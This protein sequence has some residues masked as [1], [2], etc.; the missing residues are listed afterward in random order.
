MLILYAMLEKSHLFIYKPRERDVLMREFLCACDNCLKL[1]LEQ[2]LTFE[3]DS[4]ISSVS[5]EA[6]EDEC[7]LDAE[8][9][10][11]VDADEALY[12]FDFVEVPSH[13]A[14]VSGKMAEPLYFIKV[15]EKGKAS[16][17]MYDQWN[18]VNLPGELYLKGNYL[19]K[20]RSKSPKKKNSRFLISRYY[21]NQ[22]KCLNYF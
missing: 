7:E 2:C 16:E 22:T 13:V 3:S 17:K 11:N 8:C 6:D 19:V 21:S 20:T 1:D 5:N 4:L 18:H 12:R 10:N 14:L 9:I 15:T